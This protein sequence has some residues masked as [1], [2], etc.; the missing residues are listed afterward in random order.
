MKKTILILSIVL[1]S[2]LSD[3]CVTMEELRPASID[4][5]EYVDG[6]DLFMKGVVV[7]VTQ[8]G[9]VL[10]TYKNT[11]IHVYFGDDWDGCYSYKSDLVEK[12]DVINVDG[13]M[14]TYYNNRELLGSYWYQWPGEESELPQY[15]TCDLTKDNIAHFANADHT[16]CLVTV[17][18]KVQKDGS[19]K[20]DGCN[21]YIP[22][23]EFPN[24]DINEYIGRYANVTGY[25]LWTT[26]PTIT[27]RC[28]LAIAVTD[29]EITTNNVVADKPSASSAYDLNSSGETANSYIVSSSGTYKFK[30]VKGNSSESVG[31]VASVE[32]LWESFGTDESPCIGD[33][34][35]SVNYD[36]GTVVFSTSDQF[37]EGNAVIAAKDASGTIL[38]SWHIWLTD[39]P[40]EQEYYNNAG[41]MMDRNLGATSATPG[42]V[43]ALGLLY[44]WG[45][46]DPFLGSSSISEEI[47][48]KSTASWP[49]AVSS[50]TSK[51]NVDWVTANPMTFVIGSDTSDYDWHY[52]SRNDELWKSDKTI[53]DPCPS[54]WR[55]P[56]GGTGGVWAKAVG[57]SDSFDRTYD[58]VDNGMNFS[59]LFGNSSIIWYPAAG[60]H[61][62]IDDLLSNIGFSGDYWSVT[63][64]TT[65]APRAFV[66]YQGD[67]VWPSSACQE[68][69]GLSVRCFKE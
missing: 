21:D 22:R 18:G 41:T 20:I 39:Q 2:F 40:E 1:T 34:I 57:D 43:G 28:Y 46:K 60:Y 66:F 11:L 45:R 31:S 6:E 44:Q 23:M 51:G 50:S 4:L 48:A 9:V 16:P 30:P 53:Y 47:E 55:V 37:W 19:V 25:Y 63:T 69:R 32:V 58:D 38:W 7:T 61:N 65:D 26:D 59:G 13:E 35:E 29:I 42:D 56:D 49:S 3:S 17:C 10:L 5:N 12:G 67:R 68:A 64:G 27:G 33:L 54:G 14:N 52:S 8:R 15:E 24:F 62:C 36:S